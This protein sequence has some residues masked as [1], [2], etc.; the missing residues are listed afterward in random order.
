MIVLSGFYNKAKIFAMRK[1]MYFKKGFDHYNIHLSFL[2]LLQIVQ[3][4]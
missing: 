1:K 4:K 3:C 2:S